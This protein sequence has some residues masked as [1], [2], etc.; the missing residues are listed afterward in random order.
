MLASETKLPVFVFL[1]DSAAS[2]A[3]SMARA[4]LVKLA[5]LT[6]LPSVNA[7]FAQRCFLANRILGLVSLVNKT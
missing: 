1:A 2:L 6:V 7:P 5:E 4:V 3:N